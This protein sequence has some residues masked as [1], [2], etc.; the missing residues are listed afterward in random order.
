MCGI[1]F[2]DNLEVDLVR[3][4]NGFYA[5]DLYADRIER[6][7]SEHDKSK[8]RPVIFSK[9]YHVQIVYFLFAFSA[10]YVSFS[11]K[12]NK[13]DITKKFFEYSFLSTREFYGIELGTLIPLRLDELDPLS[14]WL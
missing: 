1:D 5:P 8:V 11:F 10:K 4:K 13:L 7:V 3:D 6:I 2:R 14:L 12:L 9:L